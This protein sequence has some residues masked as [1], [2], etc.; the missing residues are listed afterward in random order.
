M[1]MIDD[2]AQAASERDCR[3][4]SGDIRAKSG[5]QWEATAGQQVSR[6]GDRRLE[7]RRLPIDPSTIHAR[8]FAERDRGAG[9]SSVILDVGEALILLRRAFERAPFL[10]G[11]PVDGLLNFLRQI[12]ILV[13]YPFSGVILQTDL[14]PRV[15]R[16]DIRMVPGRS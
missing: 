7:G 3:A 11:T 8:T 1:H 12:E 4:R 15:G 6:F 16:G 2:R 14:D 5:N 13:R 10:A 9:W